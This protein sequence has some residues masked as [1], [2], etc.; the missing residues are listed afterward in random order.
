MPHRR[1]GLCFEEEVIFFSGRI[2]L[3]RISCIRDY[4]FMP[5]TV[6]I[7]ST[8]ISY[9]IM[10]VIYNSISSSYILIILYEVTFIIVYHHHIYNCV[11]WFHTKMEKLWLLDYCFFFFPYVTS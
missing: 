1:N 9:N 8:L 4:L 11:A 10:S 7:C 6:S 2:Y 5:T 3:I